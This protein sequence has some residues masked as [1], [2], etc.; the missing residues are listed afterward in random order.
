[1][2][3]AFEH[4]SSA[5]PP[6]PPPGPAAQF[7][8]SSVARNED[9]RLLAGHG[10]YV[11]GVVLPGMLHA[12]FVRREL[13]KATI[14]HLD[15]TE[16]RRRARRRRLVHVGGLRWPLRRGMAFAMLGEKLP[17]PPP[18]RVSTRPIRRPQA[19]NHDLG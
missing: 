7:V 5:P 10:L 16:A 1:M 8:G 11:D 15:T 13:A 4:Q 9:K 14:T 19:R 18:R 12:A 17:V 2:P 3:T 6:A